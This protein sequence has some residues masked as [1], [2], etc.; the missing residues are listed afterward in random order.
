MKMQG[1]PGLCAAGKPCAIK[2]RQE[3]APAALLLSLS[4]D[5]GCLAA[6]AGISEFLT[7]MFHERRF[8]FRKSSTG[9]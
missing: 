4:G 1:R 9:T 2:T 3:G 6:A 5:C 8:Y 7:L